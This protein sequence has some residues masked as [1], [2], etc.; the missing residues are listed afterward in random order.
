MRLTKRGRSVRDFVL[1]MLVLATLA[2]WLG[3]AAYVG[4]QWKDERVNHS[5]T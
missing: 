1:L 4:Q 2:F 3:A 5:Q